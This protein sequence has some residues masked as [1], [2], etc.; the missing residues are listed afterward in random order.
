MVWFQCEDCGENLKK[1]K[2]QGHFRICS[3]YKLSC[4][5]CGETFNQQSVQGH[6]QCISEA[7]EPEPE[8]APEPA[9]CHP[10]NDDP[11]K[12]EALTRRTPELS[13]STSLFVKGKKEAKMVWF[14]C[15]DCGENL[16]K[17]KLQGHFRICSAYKLS[18][19]DCGETFNQQSVQGHTQCI[20]EAEKY[21]PKGQGKTSNATPAKPKNESKK[22]LDIDINVGLSSHPPWFCSLCNTNTTSKQTLLLHAEGKKHR[23]KARAFH[24]SQQKSSQTEEST[25]NE[26]DAVNVHSR[27]YSTEEQGIE[28]IDE[29]KG[30]DPPKATAV[31]SLEAE[32][33]SLLMKKRKF[34]TSGHGGNG[35]TEGRSD[36]NNG[37]VIQAE[38]EEAEPRKKNKHTNSMLQNEDQTGIVGSPKEATHQKIKWKKLITSILKSSPDGAMKIRKL[39][40]LVSKALQESGITQDEAQFQDM[41]MH[42]INSSSRFMLDNKL[43]QLAPKSRSWFQDATV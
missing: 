40:K 7:P 6:T 13:C 41:L 1:P 35:D 25:A 11:F 16:K 43:V 18:C 42:K 39:R 38:R 27:E 33:E 29:K 37:E 26:K 30:S 22:N 36:L 23:A 12:R 21:G 8:P 2:L 32:K 5:D 17:P 10:F 34:D 4:I 20:S 28:T 19:I 9:V 3:A 14:Q 15:E 24:A 31:S